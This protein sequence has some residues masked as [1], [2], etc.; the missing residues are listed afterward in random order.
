MTPMGFADV[1][2]A[3]ITA[4]LGALFYVIFLSV[5]LWAANKIPGRP[6][7][8]SVLQFLWFGGFMTVF[9]IAQRANDLGHITF[10]LFVFIGLACLMAALCV[11][12]LARLQ[13]PK[14]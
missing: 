12:R 13:P 9:G 4:W 10:P 11:A 6:V 3:L 8:T 7:L 2:D 5:V 14:A 1:I